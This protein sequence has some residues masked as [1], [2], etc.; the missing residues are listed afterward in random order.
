MKRRIAISAAALLGSL[1]PVSH[2]DAA[3]GRCPQYEAL[4]TIWAPRGGWSVVR[5]SRIMFRESRCDAKAVNKRG[6]DSGLLQAH[7]IVWPFLSKKFGVPMADMR[8]WLLDP[9]NNIRAG[10]ALFEFWH[11]AGRSGYQPWAV[12]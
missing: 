12:R 1:L 4:L 2:A 3:A 8:P 10:A 11:R 5:M 9:V 6:G 7:P